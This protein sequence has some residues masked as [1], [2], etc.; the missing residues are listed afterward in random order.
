MA[1]AIRLSRVGAGRP[2]APA[3]SAGPKGHALS[4]FDTV[5]SADSVHTRR[6]V[7]PVVA[8][9]ARVQ[10]LSPRP[11]TR[12]WPGVHVVDLQAISSVRKLRFAHWALWSWRHLRA[13]RPD[14]VHA[15]QVYGAG[16][17][18]AMVGFHP[19]VVSAWGSD[20]LREPRRS[21]LRRSLVRAVL[22]RADHLTVPSRAM[23]EAAVELGY[24][25]SRLHLIP[26]G[27]EP[28]FAPTPLDGS[29]T[30]RTLGIEPA[31]RVVFSPR[32]L[33]PVY[34]QEIVVAALA[35]VTREV[36]DA[37][38][39]LI[40]PSGDSARLT[41]L[42]ESIA[43]AGIALRVHWLP[44]P[45]TL[46]QM[47]RLYRMSDV[48]I[49]VPSSEGYGMT[50]YEAM[51]CGCQTVISDLPA[52]AHAVENGV[53]ALKVPVGDVAATARAL[54]S[55]LNDPEQRGRLRQAALD[56]ARGLDVHQRYRAVALLYESLLGQA[57][58]R[59]GTRH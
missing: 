25:R 51:A 8:Q 59:R 42:H 5:A 52:F 21:L 19:L 27:V 40:A 47:A 37:C 9:G 44:A 29:D 45:E 36:P 26:W 38:L 58:N 46:E 53:H 22:R 33:A 50:V 55:A 6:W 4:T 35:R 20:L 34:Q 39:V 28:L 57:R 31:T 41:R 2:A 54:T 16:W 30:R 14:I 7:D 13:L 32:G 43:A 1:L 15:H 10:V 49:S 11:L 56:M 24:P 23:L 48:V 18:G 17:L 3:S 12:D